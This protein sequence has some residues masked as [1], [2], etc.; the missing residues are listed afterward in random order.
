MKKRWWIKVTHYEYWPM[1]A[2]YLPLFPYF[3][4][5]GI[6]KGNIFYFT[7]ANPGVDEFGGL[8]FDSKNDIDKQIPQN[9]RPKAILV[10][11]FLIQN[12]LKEFIEKMQFDYPVI[13]KPDNG[14]RGKGVLK[15]ENSEELLIVLSKIQTLHLVQEY[16]PYLV[17]F[18]VF[19]VYLPAKNKYKISSLTEKKF[20]EIIGNG[21]QTITELILQKERGI[22][23]YKELKV[24]SALDFNSIPNEN[25]TLIIHTHGNHCKGT[26]F[27]DKCNEITAKMEEKFNEL[28]K[29]LNGFYYG[30]FDIKVK[31]ITDLESFEHLKIIEFNGVAAEPIHIYDNNMG[32]FKSLATFIQHWQYLD[33]ISIYLK[34]KGYRAAKFK[35][36]WGKIFRRYF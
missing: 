28:M 23:F 21:K 9:F 16:I 4:I 24:N 36:V 18:G 20:F 1:W 17:E 5:K 3:L 25:E 33:S 7:N 19:I 30:R 26:Q 2:F 22:A 6:F 13:I 31:S 11:P 29:N 15:I 32:Y 10:K 34:K 35:C 12:E 14:E 27:A 8:F